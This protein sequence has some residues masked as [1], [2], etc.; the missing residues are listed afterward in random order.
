MTNTVVVL[1]ETECTEIELVAVSESF[2][3]ANKT[4]TLRQWIVRALTRIACTSARYPKRTIV[5]SAALAVLLAVTGYYTNANFSIDTDQLWT[6]SGTVTQQREQW[7]EATFPRALSTLS[8]VFHGEH[9]N[10]ILNS[11]LVE[12]MFDVLESIQHIP[13]YDTLCQ[14]GTCRFYGATGFWD[15]IRPSDVSD[16]EAVSNMTS[17][18]VNDGSGYTIPT[19]RNQFFSQLVANETL[20]VSATAARLVV[21]VPNV[22]SI[23]KQWERQAIETI[24][25]LRQEESDIFVEVLGETSIPDELVRALEADL[26]LVPIVVALMSICSCALLGVSVGL[27]AIAAVLFSILAGAGILCIIGVPWTSATQLMP[28]LILGI[29]LDDAI[30]LYTTWRRVNSSSSENLRI[31]DQVTQMIEA[32]GLS[33]F[34]TTVTSTLAFSLGTFTSSV[35]AIYWLCQYCAPTIALVLVYQLT[36][37]IACL[38]ETEKRALRKNP[39]LFINFKP[40]WL[41]QKMEWYAENLLG[42]PRVVKVSVILCFFGFAGFCASRIPS[43]T[44]EVKLEDLLPQGSYAASFLQTEDRYSDAGG[45]LVPVDTYF[46]GYD[47]ANRTTREQL[48]NRVQDELIYHGPD[49][50]FQGPLLSWM[51]AFEYYKAFENGGIEDSSGAS[52]QALL[53]QFLNHPVYGSIFGDDIAFQNG[54]VVASRVS[55][56]LAVD[57]SDVDRLLRAFDV[58]NSF[59]TESTFTHNK[60]YNVW[61]FYSTVFSEVVM[62]TVLGIVAVSI[63]SLAFVPRWGSLHVISMICLLYSDLVGVVQLSGLH[64]NGITFVCITMSIGLLVDFCLHLILRFEEGPSCCRDMLKS[65]GS[66]VLMGGSTTLLGIAPLAFSTSEAFRTVFI[67]FLAIVSIG[68]GHGLILLPLILD[69]LPSRRK[70]DIQLKVSPKRPIL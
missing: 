68:V 2:E 20:L 51:D 55:L 54:D 50:D 22:D 65:M 60:I 49:S 64:L 69:V 48:Q 25:K 14:S 43:L 45:Q 46:I 10:N 19:P 28:F 35:P 6:P 42:L 63:V 18:L 17:A 70:Q 41:D 58:A 56:W 29:G 38:V 12:R 30:I 21:R 24:L 47:F 31:E 33:I 27:A 13:Q 61:E 5:L 11:D 26:P 52:F 15:H 37:F 1:E 4:R 44:Q 3:E 32:A 7:I 66:S 57:R 67:I 59:A 23:T 39:D 36:F 40:P 34:L 53:S 8:F 16:V 62:A 9:H